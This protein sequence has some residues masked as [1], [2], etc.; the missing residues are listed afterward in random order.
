[1]LKVERMKERMNERKKE[2]EEERKK[3]RMIFLANYGKQSLIYGKIMASLLEVLNPLSE[4]LFRVL[5]LLSLFHTKAYLIIMINNLALIIKSS[6]NLC[7][8]SIP[9]INLP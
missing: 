8:L 7:N 6:F 5:F 1:M 4:K 9:I 3:E 2:E